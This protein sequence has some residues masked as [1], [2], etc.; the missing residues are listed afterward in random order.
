VEGR[1]AEEGELEEA[2]GV[3]RV[4]A[5]G[6][7]RHRTGKRRGQEIAEIMDRER[8]TV[9]VLSSYYFFPI[10][11]TTLWHSETPLSE[12]TDHQL[13]LSALISLVE[14]LGRL[15]AR[16]QLAHTQ[17]AADT[18][19]RLEDVRREQRVVVAVVLEEDV[20]EEE[21]RFRRSHDELIHQ[22]KCSGSSEPSQGGVRKG[23]EEVAAMG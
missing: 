10:Q 2:E 11:S 23:T 15:V 4:A 21:M 8:S 22:R 6:G 17:A 16:E 3:S 14:Q 19:R 18:G 7:D 1:V 5:R 9:D 12:G 13:Q 20:E